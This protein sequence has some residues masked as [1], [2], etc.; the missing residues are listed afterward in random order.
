MLRLLALL[1]VVL[2]AA[3]AFA[4]PNADARVLEDAFQHAVMTGNAAAVLD[5]YAPDAYIIYPGLDSEAHGKA[6]IEKLVNA[7]LANTKGTEVVLKSLTVV[8]L[9]PNHMAT[10]GDWE[11]KIAGKPPVRIRTSEVLVKRDGRWLY[12][13]DHA[14]V[15][16]PRQE[17]KKVEERPVRRGQRRDR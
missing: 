9:D 6:D 1:A 13:V 12:L 15:G 7:L 5:C 8:P 14:S 10:V 4:D 11:Q 3:P 2:L 16:L 17:A